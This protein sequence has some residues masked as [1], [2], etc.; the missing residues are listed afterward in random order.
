MT[1]DLGLLKK[2]AQTACDA[3]IG[4]GAEFADVSCGRGTNLG[5]DIENN[6]IKSTDAHTNGGISVRAIYKGGTG[7]SS[8]DVL[9]V[10]AA[11]GAG[12]DAAR[13]ARLAEPDPDFI[14]LPSPADSYPK[15]KGLWDERIAALDA[16]SIIKHALDNVDGALAVCSDAVVRGG[17]SCSANGQALV[18]SLGVSLASASSSI[19]G[20]VMVIVRKG[21]DVGSFYDFDSARVLDDFEP[22]GLGASAAEQAM[23][24]LGARK[25]DTAR[26]PII[27]GPL[28]SRSV[29][30][31]IVGGADAED[32]QR[33]RSYLMGKLGE[34]IASDIVTITDDPLIPRGLASRPHDPEGVPSKPLTIVENGVLKSYL[35]STYTAG[36]A[37]V[38]PTGHGTRGG[39]ASPS[40]LVPKL[41]EMT[42]KEIIKS[43]REGLY[44]N[45]GGISPND[46]T[47]DV[48]SSVDFGMKIEN[49][50]LAYP[51]KS[52]MVG[53][54]FLEMLANIDA[55]SS[56]YREEPGMIMPTLRIQDV[57]V[58]GA[59]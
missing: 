42:G 10:D 44:I 25:I 23:Q 40:N 3:A 20:Y 16:K 50:E 24:F 8:C 33:G 38:S 12:R 46:V 19:G 15:V 2:I 52:T 27:L 54:K 21:D 37:G 1:I 32:I 4:A 51:V 17:F 22:A 28:A 5:V 48:S 49:G 34:K 57:Q 56:D 26:M 58:A 36:K 13:L 53:G 43:T 41:G 30:Y 29:L 9:T 31:G 45:M 59:K 35:Y 39:G 18:N 47:G 7:W 55:I 11:A 6:A 14:T